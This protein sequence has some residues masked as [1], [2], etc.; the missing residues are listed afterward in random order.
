VGETRDAVLL[1]VPAKASGGDADES[2]LKAFYEENKTAS[3]MRPEQRTLEYV[4][5]NKAEIERLGSAKK[6]EESLTR[7]EA[8]H[9]FGN[10]VED[11]LAAGK[12]MG[13]A[14]AKAGIEAA[15]RTLT[16]AT[17]ELGKTSD[18]EV[19]KTVVEQGFGLGEGEIS[20]LISTKTGTMLMVSAK[21]ISLTEPKPFEE[22]RADV[23]ARLSKQ[24]IRDGAREKANTVKA[25]LA[26][27]PNWQ[28]V[29]ETHGLGTRAV[30][31]IARPVDGKST[32][33]GVPLALQQAIFERKVGEVAGPL[34][35]DNG[36]QLLALIT[37]SRLPEKSA[38]LA[39]T[40]DASRMSD[41][42]GQDVQGRAYES[43]SKAHK[44]TINPALMRQQAAE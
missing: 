20:R 14:F 18:D 33:D 30:S 19:V 27:A 38:A 5:L 12:T 32:T 35:L 16:H 7:E 31:R 36:D 24:L 13:E 43:F 26:K 6:G 28:A 25:D 42:L 21:K 22:V 11:E 41:Q 17:A 37:Q 40:K 9:Q 3:Y 15:P 8:L 39:S 34:T 2:T 44:V 4:V 10:T 29:A 23:E 1:T